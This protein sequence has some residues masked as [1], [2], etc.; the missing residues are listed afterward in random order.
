MFLEN[1][2]YAQVTQS[3]VRTRSGREV[4]ALRLRRLPATAGTPYSVQ[5]NDRLDIMAQRR[6]DDSTRFWRIAD[7]NSELFAPEL[8]RRVLREIRV[9]EQ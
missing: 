9:P 6:Y 1:S 4:S 3:I 5:G 7:A 8:V 2:R